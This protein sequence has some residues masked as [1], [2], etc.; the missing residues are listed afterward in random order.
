MNKCLVITR[1]VMQLDSKH[2]PRHTIQPCFVL[3]Q[4]LLDGQNLGC[5]LGCIEVKVGI[6]QLGAVPLLCQWEFELCHWI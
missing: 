5:V 2:R 3:S 4:S 6:E 1:G